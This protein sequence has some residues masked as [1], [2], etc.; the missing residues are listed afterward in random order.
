MLDIKYVRENNGLIRKMLSDRNDDVSLADRFEKLDRRRRELISEVEDLKHK[1]NKLSS[2][3]GQAIK[4]G[5]D[6]GEAKK[7]VGKVS[8]EIKELDGVLA[9]VEEDFFNLLDRLPNVPNESVPVGKSE[10]DNPVVRTWGKKKEF[11]FEPRDHLVLGE[12][13]SLFDFDRASKMSGSGFPLFIGAGARLERA[14]INYMLDFH[15]RE[16]GYKEVSPPFIVNRASMRGTGQIPKL[17]E[18]MYK[19][20]KEDFFLIPTAEVPVTN[21]HAGEVLREEDLPIRYTAYTPC[22]RRE[23]GS[24]GKDTKGLSRVHQFDKVELVKFVRPEESLKQLEKLLSDAEEILKSLGLHYRVIELCTGD[25]SFAAHKCYDIELWAAA[26]EKWLEVSSCS[27]FSDFQARRANI[28][29][30]T[31][32]GSQKNRFVHTLNGSGVALPRLVIALLEHYQNR[33]GTI[34]VPE[35]LKT[36]LGVEEIGSDK[37]KS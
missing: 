21:I 36:Y 12:L 10:K 17:E 29:Y 14:L 20:E 19:L 35:R 31:A 3:I 25:L 22:F 32:G 6:P 16:H 30:K 26:S 5:K 27:V 8:S 33:D 2:R 23:A 11:S 7:A 9:T 37:G 1:K 24:Y 13:N 34:T 15:T 4:E 28:R 18:D